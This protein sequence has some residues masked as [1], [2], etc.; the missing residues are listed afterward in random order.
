MG[1]FSIEMKNL[2]S[3]KATTLLHIKWTGMNVPL[4]KMLLSLNI[5]FKEKI[6]S[7]AFY[8]VFISVFSLLVVILWFIELNL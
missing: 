8:P 1:L 3:V 7:L 4:G 5:S 2:L 6:Q